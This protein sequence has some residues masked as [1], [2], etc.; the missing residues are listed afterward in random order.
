M[1]VGDWPIKRSTTYKKILVKVESQYLAGR[2]LLI[3]SFES[4]KSSLTKNYFKPSI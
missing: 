3:F 2:A 1:K 4:S